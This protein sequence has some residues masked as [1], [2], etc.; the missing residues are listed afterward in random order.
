MVQIA[1]RENFDIQDKL[2]DWNIK[3]IALQN[4]PGFYDFVSIANPLNKKGM[5]THVNSTDYEKVK[6]EREIY[7]LAKYF[8]F[9]TDP[10]QLLKLTSMKHE[11]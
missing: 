2:F 11:H 8:K 9:T 3:A 7:K 1:E 10:R 5:F 4:F 6:T